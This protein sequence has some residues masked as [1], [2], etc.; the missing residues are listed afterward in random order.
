MEGVL[1]IPFSHYEA[2][3]IGECTT[4]ADSTPNGTRMGVGCVDQRTRSQSFGG[5]GGANVAF[6][7]PLESQ[8]PGHNN[9]ECQ[10]TIKSAIHHSGSVT[11]SR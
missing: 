4:R 1:V 11:R 5:Y 9:R 2:R 10:A 8:V 3:S 6:D 7:M